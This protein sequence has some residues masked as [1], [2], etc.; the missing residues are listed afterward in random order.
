LQHRRGGTAV[1]GRIRGYAY[2]VSLE[3]FMRSSFF[4]PL[5]IR[6][7][8]CGSDF[9]MN[10]VKRLCVFRLCELRLP[11]REII[12]ERKIIVNFSNRF[13]SRQCGLNIYL[14]GGRRDDF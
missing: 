12:A 1:S 4:L 8:V 3:R 11:N 6:H 7:P 9:H 13:F 10:S 2:M 5:H 14:S